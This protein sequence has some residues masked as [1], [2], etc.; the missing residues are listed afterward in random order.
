MRNFFFILITCFIVLVLIFSIN[1]IIKSKKNKKEDHF[2]NLKL[3]TSVHPGLPWSFTSA[4]SEI[5]IKVGDVVTLD[6]IVKN[7]SEEKTSGMATFDYFPKELS[8]YISKINCFCY[9]VQTL[10]ANEEIKYS[11]IFLIDPQ[12]TKDSKTKN[13]NEAI[14]QFVFFKK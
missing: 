1:N 4:K 14:I 9:E 13:I 7:L 2:I 8:K 5:K 6:Y 11:M 10:F 3:I 12:A